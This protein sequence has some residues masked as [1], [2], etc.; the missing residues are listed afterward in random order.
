MNQEVEYQQSCF[1]NYLTWTAFILNPTCMGYQYVMLKDRVGTQSSG[2]FLFC[3]TCWQRDAQPDILYHNKRVLRF[4][5]QPHERVCYSVISVFFELSTNL[6]KEVGRW[7]TSTL[8]D[9]FALLHCCSFTLESSLFY[10]N[11]CRH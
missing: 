7:H 5:Y 4:I 2:S 1:K 6:M 8:Y 9:L 3:T 10:C 11:Y